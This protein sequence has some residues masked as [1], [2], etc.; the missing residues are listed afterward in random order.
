M[1]SLFFASCDSRGLF[2]QLNRS[3]IAESNFRKAPLRERKKII[4]NL[5]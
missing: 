3:L 4:R 2:T 5:R 1:R